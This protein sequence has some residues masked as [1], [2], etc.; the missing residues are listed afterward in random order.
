LFELGGAGTNPTASAS[1][2]NFAAGTFSPHFSACESSCEYPDFCT[3]SL[4]IQCFKQAEVAH[5]RDL[6]QNQQKE[7][8][9]LQ[10]ARVWTE[11]SAA[12]CARLSQLI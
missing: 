4:K 7:E 12:S 9:E 10:N 5:F 1:S 6:R 2:A 11:V 8:F 3:E